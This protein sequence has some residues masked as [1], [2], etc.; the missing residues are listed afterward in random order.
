MK[1]S[2][3]ISNFLEEISSLSYSIVCLYFFALITEEGFLC[4]LAT[5]WNSAFRWIYLS[6]SPLPLA[7]LLFSAICKASSDNIL[8][9][10][11]YFSWGWSLSLPPVQC[12]EPLSL[13]LRALCLPDIIPWIYL[14][15]SLYNH[16]GFDSI[17]PEWSTGIPYFLQLNLNFA[18]RS[19]WSEPQS[20][21]GL[22][23]ADYIELLHLWLQRM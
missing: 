16:K 11:I 22:I 2:F 7:S 13:V 18:T 8:S 6:Y 5:L 4:F 15:L 14:S 21:P 12:H 19:S 3:G 23:F 20:A 9:F 1:C 17:I 10:C